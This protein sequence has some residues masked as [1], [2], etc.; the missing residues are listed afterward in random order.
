MLT[1]K[2][3]KTIIKE[4]GSHNKDTGSTSIQIALLTREI[5]DLTAHL[6][7]HPKDNHSRR[8][9]LKMVG[10]RRRLLNYISKIDPKSYSTLIKK[11]DIKK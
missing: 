1:S 6:K 8:G 4:H 5:K 7:K 10:K 2:K 3:K 11:L 9:L